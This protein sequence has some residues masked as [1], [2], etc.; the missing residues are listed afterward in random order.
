MN[1]AFFWTWN[2]S[3]NILNGLLE[4]EDIKVKFVVSQPDKRVGRK[5]ELQITPLK[6]LAIRHDIIV[7][8]PNTLKKDTSITELSWE[9]DFFIVVAYGKIIPLDILNIPKHWSINLHGSVLPK[10]R[11]ASPVQESLKNGDLKTW[12]TTMYMSAWMDEGDILLQQK[13]D[14]DRHDTQ[15]EIFEKFEWIWAGLLYKTLLS[16]T[17]NTVEPLKQDEAQVIYCKKIEKHDG[18]IDFKN[19]AA[20]QIYNLYRAYTPWPWI[21]SEYYWKKINIEECDYDNK[22]FTHDDTFKIWAVCV[23][24]E[25]GHEKK[26]CVLCKKW[27]LIIKKVKLEWKKTMNILDFINGNK[28][29]LDYSF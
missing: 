24:E 8:Q 18:K 28:E 2:F 12:L 5:N 15:W 3:K 4:Y 20:E 16:I 19:M 22:S 13:I 14:I 10:Y 25:T 29:F 21:Y 17:N 23:L 1:I 27:I 6:E 11:W 7:L 26:I 9:I